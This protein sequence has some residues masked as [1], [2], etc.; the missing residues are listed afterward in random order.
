MAPPLESRSS[1]QA[2]DA[3]VIVILLYNA[4]QLFLGIRLDET[5]YHLDAYLVIH[6]CEAALILVADLDECR[7]EDVLEL[8]VME[9]GNRESA[10]SLDDGV[11]S[12]AEEGLILLIVET[13]VA[14]HHDSLMKELLAV[15]LFIKGLNGVVKNIV[16]EVIKLLLSLKVP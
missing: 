15:L 8:L 4:R 6:D 9:V 16:K 13:E 14:D 7:I 11:L 12:S 3:L 1:T 10:K 5:H 2:A